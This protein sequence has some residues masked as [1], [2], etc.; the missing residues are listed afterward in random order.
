MKLNQ[1]FKFYLI[2]LLIACSADSDES[3]ITDI[4][5][6]AEFKSIE[7]VFEESSILEV[8]FNKALDRDFILNFI[9]KLDPQKSIF[10]KSDITNFFSTDFES[11]YF[12]FREIVD[13]FYIR[14]LGSLEL[15]FEILNKHNFNFTS[16]DFISFDTERDF[17]DDKYE[18]YN[19]EKRV[20]KNELIN[21]ML[22]GVLFEDARDDLVSVYE[23]RISYVNKIRSDDKFSVLANNFLSLLDPHSSYFSQR[24]LENWN[25]RMNLSFEGIGA[26]LSYENEKAKIEELMPGGPAMLSKKINVGDKII[27][28]GQGVSGEMINVIGWRLDDIVDSIRGDEGTIVKLEIETDTGNK[29]IEIQRGKISL[30]ESDASKEIIERNGMKIGYIDLPSFYSEIECLRANR[31]GCKSATADVK[32]FLI[33]FKISGVDAVILDL[34]NNGGGYLHEADSLTRLFIDYGPTVQVK[35][36]DR[37]VEIYTTWQTTKIWNKPLIVMVNKYSA[38]ASEIF[39]GAMQDYNRGLIVGQTT[40]GKGSVQ[41]FK[42]TLNGQIKLTDSLYFRVTGQPTQL[43]GIDPDL[44]FPSVMDNADIGEGEYDNAIK[45]TKIN[46]AKFLPK[47]PFKLEYFSYLHNDR[48]SKSKYFTKVLE[49]QTF[50]D[51]KSILSLNFSVR[52]DQQNKD[53]K[54]TLELINLNR[55]IAGLEPLKSYQEYLDLDEDYD[56]ILDAEI[57]QSLNILED[58]ILIES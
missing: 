6:A 10:T 52:K 53:R 44:F 41:R 18:I 16:N 9:Y 3:E 8:D 4:D 23:D 25:L 13:V 20:V 22:D 57:D 51:E 35:S 54:R 11:N 29:I 47:K 48:I 7:L 36:P 38:S 45:P 1:F 49:I 21:E 27:S 2:F 46:K 56:F 50:D 33:D 30:E 31:Y 58:L 32:R 28:I 34:R 17:M 19:Y 43:D 40:F 14:Y 55:V 39:A 26:V 24:D 5:Y 15:R 12:L 42:E 37:D